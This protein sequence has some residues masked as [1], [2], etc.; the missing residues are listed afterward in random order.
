MGANSNRSF[1]GSDDP[2]KWGSSLP[3]PSFG[4][5]NLQ[6]LWIITPVIT[7]LIIMLI[8]PL[9]E[10]DLF[11]NLKV[12]EGIY[13]THQIPNT[14]N[15]SITVAGQPYPYARYWLSDLVLYLVYRWFGMSGMVLLQAL[16]G[17]I[18]IGLLS[19]ESFARRAN[20][21]ATAIVLLLVMLFPISHARSQ[22]FTFLFFALFAWILSGF[23][24]QRSQRLW[25]LPLLMAI[26][27]NMHPGWIM[28]LALLGLVN[29]L[30]I[31]ETLLKR[32][33]W[34]RLRLLLAWSLVTALAVV[35]YPRGWL[36]Y[37][38]V[39]S[40]TSNPIIHSLITEWQ[41]ISLADT[42]TYP[43]FVLLVFLLAGLSFSRRRLDLYGFG[44]ILVFLSLAFYMIRLIPFYYIVAAPILAA[45]LSELPLPRLSSKTEVK[46]SNPSVK[47][48]ANLVILVVMLAGVV[49]C[50]PPVRLRLSGQS[51]NVLLHRFWPQGAAD[52]LL[53]QKQTGMRIY[54]L[55]DWSG[56]L[57]WRLYPQ[58]QVFMTSG[59]ELY[60]MKILQ[61]YL[62]IYHAEPGWLDKLKDYQ[63]DYLVLST[64]QQST[65]VKAAQEAKLPEVYSD[66][67]SSIFTVP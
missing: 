36:I 34:K 6:T 63:V 1:L 42:A 59:V 27:V 20:P 35:I 38:D 13:T 11:W 12:G 19:A 3:R 45:L 31:L 37:Q 9:R 32:M 5:L 64:E 48:T 51:S 65:L 22:M 10:G 55:Q 30:A 52:Y 56:Y 26:W 17:G 57:L 14:D 18:I 50:L 66:D 8:T 62:T 41:P 61:D 47:A 23:W 39:L 7:M 46:G 21:R 24:Y 44:L 16:V 49:I 4:Q 25:L 58:G 54:N 2:H 28:G 40:T 43:F 53:A 15:F 33:E 29:G 67:I 60:T